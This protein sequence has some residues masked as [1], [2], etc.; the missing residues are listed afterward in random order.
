LPASIIIGPPFEGREKLAH[1]DSRAVNKKLHTRAKAVL[2]TKGTE[3]LG[4]KNFKT[5]T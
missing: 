1:D 3:H 2:Y 5:I 4:Y